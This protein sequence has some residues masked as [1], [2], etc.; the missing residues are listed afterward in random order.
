MVM[1]RRSWVAGGCTAALLA[2]GTLLAAGP[3]TAASTPHQVVIPTITSVTPNVVRIPATTSITVKGN[4]FDPAATLGVL[5]RLHIVSSHVVDATTITATV[6]AFP[7]NGAGMDSLKVTNPGNA[8]AFLR[9]A[10]VV[11]STV[12]EFH[13]VPPTRVLDTRTGIGH[14]HAGP[15]FGGNSF[16]FP[17]SPPIPSTG[18]EAVVMNVTATNVTG[19]GFVTVWP[20]GAPQPASSNLQVT[21]GVTN[22]VLATV[23]VNAGG[24]V[25][26]AYSATGSKAD[27]IADVV[28]WYARYDNPSAGAVFSPLAP[29]RKLDTRDPAFGPVGPMAA[30]S[31]R[32]VQLVPAGTGVTAAAINLTVPTAISSGFITAWAGGTRPSTS[33]INATAGTTLANAAIVPVAADG[34]ISVYASLTND[35]IVDLV[36]TFDGTSAVPGGQFVSLPVARVV[37]TRDGTGGHTGA[38]PAGSTTSFTV[39]GSG[40]IPAAPAAEAIVTT[41]T[42]PDAAAAGYFTLFPAGATRPTTSTVNFAAGHPVS[43]LAPVALST[44][45]GLSVFASAT[46][47]AVL[48]VAGYY[49]SG[50]LGKV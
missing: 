38:L 17:V 23:G 7:A 48:D 27:V 40:G 31:T 43:N 13:P 20:K 30:G 29:Q 14:G 22:A 39:T 25:D 2:A 1:F 33:N 47:D 10:I 15:L 24:R 9:N 41:V 36:G 49:A 44:T 18:V 11:R 3:A 6:Q 35:L 34:T 37:D 16:A 50:E 42:A 8:R 32:V 4:N 5:G 19:N 46:S 28:G 26:I 45:G 12:G 21:T